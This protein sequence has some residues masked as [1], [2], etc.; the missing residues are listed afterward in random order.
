VATRDISL[1]GEDEI[2]SKSASISNAGVIVGKPVRDPATKSWLVAV[3][4]PVTAREGVPGFVV[5]AHISLGAVQGVFGQASVGNDGIVT[6]FRS[7]GIV[8]LRRR[9]EDPVVGR[10]LSGAELFRRLLERPAGLH[11]AVSAS[12]RVERVISYRSID[13]YPLVVVAGLAKHEIQA[14]WW[15][16]AKRDLFLALAV[17]GLLVLLGTYVRRVNRGRV[18]AENASRETELEFRLLAESATDMI[19]RADLDTT[20]RYISPASLEILGYLPQELVATKPSQFAHPD[21]A[22]AL[23]AA[24]DDLQNGRADTAVTI[25][26]ARHKN[27]SWVWL[28]GRVRLLRNNCGVPTGYVAALRDIS[29]RRQLEEELRELATTDSLTGLQNRRSFE[30]KFAEEWGRAARR[31]RPV[32]LLL[33]DVDFFKK[34]NDHYGHAAGD[35]CLKRV[36]DILRDGRRTG[37]GSAVPRNRALS[38]DL[39]KA[40][41]RALYR[42]KDG[43]RNQVQRA[44]IA[45]GSRR[46]ALRLVGA[47]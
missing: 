44:P 14:V 5:V 35:R 36:A 16:E 12:D 37:D 18:I 32:G 8:L 27:G 17:T 25:N 4:R 21:D 15:A 38:G 6:L 13:G 29:V 22:G 23:K 41:D 47:S 46:P 28:E 20:R 42:A 33:I 19:V 7:D 10:D 24:L 39:F 11:E 31:G 3:G 2:R 40:G 9:Y 34:Y 45:G 26:R 1:E 30:S 43:G